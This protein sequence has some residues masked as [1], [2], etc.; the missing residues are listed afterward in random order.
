[1]KKLMKILMCVCVG[2]LGLSLNGHAANEN[3][4]RSI[5]PPYGPMI[6]MFDAYDFDWDD[7]N[8]RI[9]ESEEV[10]HLGWEVDMQIST[11]Y[12]FF[13]DFEVN[14]WLDPWGMYWFDSGYIIDTKEVSSSSGVNRVDTVRNLM[15]FSERWLL[16]GEQPQWDKVYAELREDKSVW[17]NDNFV[18]GVFKE[19]NQ[20]EDGVLVATDTTWSFSPVL[21]NVRFVMPN[22]VHTYQTRSLSFNPDPTAVQPISG[23]VSPLGHGGIINRPIDP[24]PLDGGL[25]LSSLRSSGVLKSHHKLDM[26]RGP[27]TSFNSTRSNSNTA[28]VYIEQTENGAVHVYNLYGSGIIDNV[29]TQ[30]ADSVVEFSSQVLFMNTG[31]TRFMFNSELESFYFN[32][33]YDE[34]S[35]T[36]VQ[37]N[38]GTISPDSLTWSTTYPCCTNGLFGFFYDNNVLRYTDGTQFVI[39]PPLVRLG[40]VNGDGLVTIGDLTTLID[41]LLGS[42][43]DGSLSI[44]SEAADMNIDGK[45]SIGDVTALIDLLLGNSH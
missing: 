10:A 39:Q 34:N 29:F 7:E 23:G 30:K 28:L 43:A 13:E 15:V 45:V 14:I 21:K 31:S 12:G 1:M 20:Y 35:N 32:Y 38:V 18:F 37:S 27:A 40:D 17:F 6:A 8:N 25:K 2:L 36:Y 33:S 16:D 19:V 44:N 9:I 5:H 4:V 41:C 3:S 24:K 42:N 11:V 22:G 26:H